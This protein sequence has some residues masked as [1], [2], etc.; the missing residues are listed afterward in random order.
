MCRRLLLGLPHAFRQ[1]RR[2]RGGRDD[3]LG[4]RSAGRRI[5]DRG[6]EAGGG[7]TSRP[8]TADAYVHFL[9]Y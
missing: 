5:H 9:T 4:A 1:P 6:F 8:E 3:S 2:K 7:K